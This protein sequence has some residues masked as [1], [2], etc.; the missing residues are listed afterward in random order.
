MTTYHKCPSQRVLLQ[1]G[2]LLF[3]VLCDPPCA[4]LAKET[5]HAQIVAGQDALY[6]GR[7]EE[8]IQRFTTLTRQYPTDPKGYFFL[9]LTQRWLT[10]I[11]PESE[12]AQKAFE[13]SAQK[14]I[15]VAQTRLEQQ[16][17]DVEALLYLAATYGYRAEYY[18]FLKDRWNKAYDD[19][20]R[21]WDALQQTQEL[22]LADNVDVQLGYGLYYYYAYVYRKKIGWWQF[23]ISLPSGDKAKGI[24]L[25]K[26]VR[27]QG[28]YLRV[29]A[30]YFLADIYKRD[31]EF[32]AQA[33]PLAEAL[34]QAYP[35]NPYFH[36]FLAG[37]YHQNRNWSSSIRTAQEILARAGTLPH[38]SDYIVYQATYLIGESEFYLGHYPQ[39]LRQFDAII[40]AQPVT[41]AYLLPWA[42][43]RRGAIYDLIGQKENA[44]AEYQLVLTFDDVL[45]VHDLAKAFLKNQKKKP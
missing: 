18:N 39:A 21:M 16:P 19:G 36:I 31:P 25:V 3:V 32:K 41:P 35:E 1:L 34:H 10:R 30:W 9:A 24:A 13:Q 5:V 8:A 38:Y 29:E 44:T 28:T 43:L 6:H 42:H 20:M 27:D 37:I 7:F 12:K 14:C 4:T 15:T 17:D 2:C 22:S 33:A 23:L 11:D 40:T 45:H 26:M